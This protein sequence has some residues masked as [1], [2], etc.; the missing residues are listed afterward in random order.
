MM[1]PAHDERDYEFASIHNIEII[2]VIAA[3]EADTTKQTTTTDDASFADESDVV[4]QGV[5]I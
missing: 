3:D 4:T 1:V 5:M 2:P